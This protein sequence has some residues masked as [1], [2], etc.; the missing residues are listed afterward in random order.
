MA[1]SPISENHT[2]NLSGILDLD[3]MSMDFDDIGSKE[4]RDLLDKFNN[5]YVKITVTLRNDC[6]E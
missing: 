5:E 4:L 1:K 2:L 3:N 6:V